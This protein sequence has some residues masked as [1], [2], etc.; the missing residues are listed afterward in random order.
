MIFL[1][2][3]NLVYKIYLCKKCS[4]IN[5]LYI[6][7]RKHLYYIIIFVLPFAYLNK[8]EKGYTFFKLLKIFPFLSYYVSR[9]KKTHVFQNNSLVYILQKLSWNKFP[10]TI[11]YFIVFTAGR[12]SAYFFHS[13]QSWQ[14]GTQGGW[15]NSGV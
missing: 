1:N 3:K 4:F 5:I 15:L 12:P 9:L 13:E 8:F 11:S 6:Y 7:E 2:L 14:R 10:F